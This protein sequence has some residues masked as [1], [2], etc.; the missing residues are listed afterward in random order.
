MSVI[1]IQL[2][3]EGWFILGCMIIYI[4]Y[5]NWQITTYLTDK[6]ASLSA[7][8]GY[9]RLICEVVLRRFNALAQADR[10]SKPLLFWNASAVGRMETNCVRS[11]TSLTWNTFASFFKASSC[12]RPRFVSA[13]FPPKWKTS[14]ALS[15]CQAGNSA[16]N[17]VKVTDVHSCHHKITIKLRKKLDDKASAPSSPWSHTSCR[18]PLLQFSWHCRDAKNA[19]ETARKNRTA[20]W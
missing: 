18:A 10:L 7:L 17:T 3:C 2:T 13:R 20:F 1:K 15:K 19:K 8:A 12:P 6:Y 4:I 14:K 9:F 11:S 5:L 16:S